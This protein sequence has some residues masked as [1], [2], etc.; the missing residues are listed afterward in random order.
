MVVFLHVIYF[1]S[2]M[3]LYKCICWHKRKIKEEATGKGRTIS[4]HS[5]IKLHWLQFS[6]AKI[7]LIISII[8][9]IQ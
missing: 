9:F 3:K 1:F 5:I 4:S 2:L 7:S 6:S 8:I